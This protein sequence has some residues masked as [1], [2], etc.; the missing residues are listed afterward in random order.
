[1]DQ[2]RKKRIPA[3]KEKGGQSIYFVLWATFSLFAFLILLVTGISYRVVMERSYQF[4]LLNTVTEKGNEI[5]RALDE[6]MPPAYAGDYSAYIRFLAQDHDVTIFVLSDEGVVLYPTES[7]DLPETEEI[8]RFDEKTKQ[9]KARLM[10]SNHQYATYVDISGDYVYGKKIVDAAGVETYLY[11]S[12]SANLVQ[13]IVTRISERMLLVAGFI[14]ILSFAISSGISGLIIK[15]ITKMT[16]SAKR[17]AQGDFEVDFQG[18]AFGSEMDELA[19]TLN[20]ARDEI[21]KADRMQKELIANVSHDFKTPLT[22]IKAYASMIIEISGNDPEKRNR[23]AQV[24]IDETD[25]LTSLVT[26]VLDISKIRAGI[27]E[28]KLAETDVSVQVKE[29]LE[30]FRY[31]AETQGYVF[32]TQIEDGLVTRADG[33]K[34]GQVLYNLIGNAVNYTGE[35]KKVR[36][37]LKSEGEG[38]FR[39]SVQDTGKGIK[40]DEI[41]TIWDRYYRSSEMHKRPVQG[42]GLGLSIVKTILEKHAFDF[43]VESEEGKGSTFYVVFPSIVKPKKKK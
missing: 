40:Q 18:D 15:P 30:K 21:F 1:M 33:V 26:D 8:N 6:E 39:F 4:E 28:L 38:C 34:I 7:V 35:D 43:G 29:V 23:H 22:M 42:T 41:Q 3:Y 19:Q 24:I 32:E 11:V 36:V 13:S 27:N 9:L 37:C 20:F 10:A 17:L 5:S 12:K 2:G 16:E 25:R 31:L 14:F